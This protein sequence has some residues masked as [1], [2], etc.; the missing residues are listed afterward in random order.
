MQSSPGDF[1]C[2]VCRQVDLMKK[3]SVVYNAGISSGRYA[4]ATAGVVIGRGVMVGHSELSGMSQTNLSQRLT[5]PTPPARPR[6]RGCLST[7]GIIVSAV[8][9]AIPLQI[10]VAILFIPHKP[11][12]ADDVSTI[13]IMSII[14]CLCVASVIGIMAVTRPKI[15]AQKA[16]YARAVQRWYEAMANWE[17][18][19][20]C[21][22]DDVVFFPGIPS[23]C[24]SAYDIYRLL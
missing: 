9:G 20:Y 19:Y 10:L 4:G 13:T 3:V 5:P 21:E 1:V 7:A 16:E 24:V 12:N 8:I 14:V 17:R 23:S 22:R 2:P 18:L 15:L 6:G 11:L